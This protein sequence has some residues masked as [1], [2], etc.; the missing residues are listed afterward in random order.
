MVPLKGRLVGGVAPPPPERKAG[1][2]WG[3]DPPTATKFR[4]FLPEVALPAAA[5]AGPST[6]WSVPTPPGPQCLR[7][8]AEIG[9][10]TGRVKCVTNHRGE[11]RGRAA[12]DCRLNG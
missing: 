9:N 5:T 2:G 3:V 4:G 1:G 7:G 8:G 10:P 6:G 12:Q 11:G